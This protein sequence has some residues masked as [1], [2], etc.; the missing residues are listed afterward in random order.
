MTVIASILIACMGGSV[1]M[2]VYLACRYVKDI[3]A[4]LS[5]CS[6]IQS[7]KDN[8]SSAGL[9]GKVMRTC[10]AANMLMIPGLFIRKGMADVSD[11]ESFPKPIKKILL[12][13]WLGLVLSTILFF[14]FNW[15][16]SVLT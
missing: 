16:I 1:C 4:A 12:P 9:V 11:V 8:F 3:E 2:M 14:A 7:N 5:K 13:S 15:I 10:L 6:Y